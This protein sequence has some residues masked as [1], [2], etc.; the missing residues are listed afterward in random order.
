M[1][2]PADAELESVLDSGELAGAF[3]LFGDASRLRDDGRERLVDAALG[4][5][6]RDFDLD[7]FRGGD[8]EPEEIASALSMPPMT[9]PRRVV[10][11]EDAQQL[12]PTGRKVVLS[13]V[14]DPPPGLTVVVSA[15]IPDRSRAKFY[16]EL[17]KRARSLEW[18]TPDEQEIP[19]WLMDRAES[20]HGFRLTSGAAQAMAAA[21]GEDLSL[22]ESELEKLAS[23]AGGGEVDLDR[24]RELVP[25]VRGVD[26]WD[27]LDRVA[28]RRYDSALEDLP[29]LLSEPSESAVGLLVGMIDQH[30]YLGVA[31]EGGRS[32]VSD[33]LAKA[34][35]PYLKWK[36]RIYASQARAW[37]RSEITR[38]LGLMRRADRQAK[39]GVGDRRVLEELLLSLRLLRREAA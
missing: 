14:E 12:T 13:A 1:K 21:V 24:V 7:R 27:W 6:T 20:T 32:R 39:S 33:A 31:L 11:V 23:G 28:N 18:T 35:K 36:A 29:R 17:K 5:A 4:P 30:L 2:L 26:R 25:R 9:G 34:G 10:V 37:S 22:L 3:F 16:K 38:A 19:G 15:D 8:S